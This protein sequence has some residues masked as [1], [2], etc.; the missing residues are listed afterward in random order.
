MEKTAGTLHLDV[1]KRIRE[2]QLELDRVS[3]NNNPKMNSFALLVVPQRYPTSSLR[4]EL[5]R[6]LDL[7]L[8]EQVRIAVVYPFACATYVAFIR[9][10]IFDDLW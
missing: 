1:D 7:L 5:E 8:R 4:L 2:I 10:L 9:L 3:H 6:Q